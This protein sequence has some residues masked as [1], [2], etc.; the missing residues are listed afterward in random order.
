MAILW[1][2]RLKRYDNVENNMEKKKDK[3]D[4]LTEK[5]FEEAI[6][7]GRKGYTHI[8]VISAYSQVFE[9]LLVSAALVT[10][11]SIGD[12]EKALE[13]VEDVVD[14]LEKD[15]RANFEKMLPKAKVLMDSGVFDL[16]N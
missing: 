1:N 11:A 5:L 16:P 2:G 14:A 9:R 4:I 6:K 12:K 15:V 13:F 10:Y 7:T 8:Q 3:V